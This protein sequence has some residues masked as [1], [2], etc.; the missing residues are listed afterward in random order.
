MLR[1]LLVDDESF[2]SEVLQEIL[3]RL[4]HHVET[5]SGGEEGLVM[6]D[7]HAYD[8]V[9]TDIRM[10]DIDGHGVAKHV[11]S[12]ERPCTPVIGISGTPWFLEGDTFDSVISK[13]FTVH[14]L[15]TAIDDAVGQPVTPQSLQQHPVLSMG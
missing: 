12:S 15:A 2:V 14:A 3:N 1:I 4:G 10:P 13:P 6:F 8:L 9:I 11:R 7:S 5:A